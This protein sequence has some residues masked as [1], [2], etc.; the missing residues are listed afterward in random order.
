VAIAS[1]VPTLTPAFVRAAERHF[2]ADPLVVSPDLDL[3]IEIAYHDPSS[4]GADRIA[5]AVAA[6]TVYGEPAIVVDLGTATTLDVIAKGRYEGG[7]IVPGVLTSAE[8]LMRRAA[9]LARI[10]IR[11]PER[12]VGRTTE[13]SMQAGIYFGA[14]GLIDALVGRI[15]AE[16][17]FRPHVIA[18]G[19][20]AALVAGDSETIETVDEALTLKGLRI[21]Y[22][23]NR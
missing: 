3:G 17:K 14:V 6:R 1:V 12:V 4:V 11:R 10:E 15:V 22:E 18:T 5:N 16:M 2:D 9:R 23:R 7:A 20:L 21:L 19:G 8:E 13:E